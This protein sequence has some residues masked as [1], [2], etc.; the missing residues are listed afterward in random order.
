MSDNIFQG[1]TKEQ[2]DQSK[3]ESSKV[4]EKFKRFLGKELQMRQA[5]E[6][7]AYVCMMFK[8]GFHWVND[9]GV[10]DARDPNQLRRHVNVFGTTLRGLKNQIT[11]NDPH[12]DVLPD[13]GQAASKEELDLASLVIRSEAEGAENGQGIKA[14]VKTMVD[15]AAVKTFSMVSVMPNNDPKNPRIS[16][17]MSH[18]AFDVFFDSKDMTKA[19]IVVISSYED[20]KYLQ[21]RGYINLDSGSQ[22]TGVNTPSHSVLKNEYEDMHGKNAEFNSNMVLIDNVYYIQHDTG[23]STDENATVKEDKDPTIMNIV[24]SGDTV[25]RPPMELKGYNNLSQLFFLY[26]A[27]HDKHIKYPMPWMNDAVPLQR[28]LNDASENIDTLLHWYAKV[29]VMQ[30]QGSG[31]TVQLVGD[32]H[33]QKLRYAGEKPEFMNHPQVP[34]ELFRIV[35]QRKS[36]IEDMVGVHGSSMGKSSGGRVSGRKEA[37]LAAGDS[38]NVSEP[39][40]NLENALGLIFTQVLENAADNV[41]KVTKFH[42]DDQQEITG[43]GSKALSVVKGKKGVNGQIPTEIKPFKN[44]KVKIHPG[45]N[46]QLSQSRQELLEVIQ[47]I[48]GEEMADKREAL[49]EILIRK[50]SVGL[51]RD[52]GKAFEQKQIEIESENADEHIIRLEIEKL[53]RGEVVTATP[54]QPHQEHIE[55]KMLALQEIGED[56]GPIFDAFMENIQQHDAMLNPDAQKASPEQ[57][58]VGIQ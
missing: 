4:K 19:Q 13:K 12:V 39:V 30:R 26:Y 51:N 37:V 48:S 49:V 42:G 2:D 32:R 28:S 14:L 35:E 58:F 10:P 33:A 50:Y 11:F 9:E 5:W 53:A 52:M 44:I 40:S 55:F 36:E 46:M 57:A 45:S 41:M 21:L 15:D 24:F 56:E 29:R 6:R 34:A 31:N 20:K 7:A 43:I 47:V 23:D 3:A 17:I 54:E 38:D 22:T 27:E 8:A 16:D 1:F 18:D 25:I